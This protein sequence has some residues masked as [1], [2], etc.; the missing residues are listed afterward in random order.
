ML[1]LTVEYSNHRVLRGKVFVGSFF[2]F[3][4]GPDGSVSKFRNVGKPRTRRNSLCESYGYH[5]AFIGDLFLPGCDI[6]S[7]G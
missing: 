3:C 4:R 6:V 7:L 1:I 5:S 2:L